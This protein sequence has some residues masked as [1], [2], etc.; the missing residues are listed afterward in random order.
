MYAFLRLGTSLSCAIAY[1]MLAPLLPAQKT[2]DSY[3]VKA[4][5]QKYEYRVPMRDGVKLFTSVYV[6]RDTTEDHPILLTRTPYGV[7]PYGPDAYRS[8][9]APSPRYAQSG[10][11]FVF[12]DVRGRYMSEGT[13]V[14]MTPHKDVKREPNDV[15]ESTDTY[16]TIEWLIKHIPHNNRRVGLW[17]ISYNGFFAAAG[18]IDAH[19]ALKAVSPQAPQADWFMGDDTHHNG[20]FFLTSTFNWMAWCGRRGSTQAMSCRQPFNFGTPDGYQ[21]FLDMGP[22]PNADANYFHGEV[23]GWTEMMEHGTYDRFWQSR[24]ILPHLRNIRPA[25]M[26]VGGWYDAN[27]FFGALHVYE[28]VREQSPRTSNVLVVGPWS[29][30]QWARGEGQ[31]LGP[32]RFGSRTSQYFRDNI[33]FLFFEYYLHQKEDPNLP[34]AYVFETGAN[35]WRT[36]DEWPPKG[37]AVQSI[38]LRESGTLSFDPPKSGATETFDEYESDPARPVPFV[39]ALSTDM[40]PDYMAQD[41]RF[42]VSRPDVLVYVSEPLGED[43][44]IAGP[45]TPNLFVSTTGTDSD[46]VVKLIDVYPGDAPDRTAETAE[47]N[48]CLVHMG[49]FQQLVRGDVMRG[50]FR[51]SFQNPE[52]FTP[53][54]VTNVEFTMPDVFH[55]FLKGHRIMVHIQSTWFPLVDRNPQRFEDIY[56][57]RSADFQKATERVYRS[58]KYPSEIKLNVLP[59][60]AIKP[61]PSSVSIKFRSEPMVGR[62]L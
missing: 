10:Y 56:R 53:G 1:S 8:V 3:D 47:E 55:T 41:Q 21:F 48:S 34:R 62:K 57:A 59:A 24:N 2:Q 60:N 14:Q 18:M 5:Y 15:D 29:H 35:R 30:G 7:A 50:K 25:V 46:W 49:G 17:G 43:L 33:E 4:H 6:P 31:G 58:D 23:P 27:N 26:S 9:L 32:L 38:Y 19:P 11:I 45:V 54:K 16:D 40:D 37:L 61:E 12:Q 39:P 52:P 44:T 36:F 28:S 13:F 42:A 20:A 51:T 22:L